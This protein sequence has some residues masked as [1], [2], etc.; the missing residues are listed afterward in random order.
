MKKAG[1]PAEFGKLRSLFWPIH[2]YE[3]KKMAPMF[4]MFFCISFVY[5][6]VRDTKD[7]LIVTAPGSGAE[8]IPFLKVWCV[9]PAAILLMLLYSKLSNTLSKERLFYTTIFPFIVFF[10]LFGFVIY[11]MRN[12]IQPHETAA[13]LRTI[14]PASAAGK[15]IIAIIENWP[16]AVFYILAELWGSM[17]LSLAFW[18]FANEITRIHEA[19]RFYGLLG[20]GANFALIFSGRAIVWAS[21]AGEGDGYAQ[22][23]KVLMFMVVIAGLAVIATYSWMQRN[24][25][26]DPLYYEAAAIPQKKKEKPKLSMKESLLFLTRSKY[27]GCIAL[28]VIAYGASI[29]LVEVVW[30]SQLK[31]QYPN[32]KEYSA[33]M[34]HFSEMTGI[35]TM[36]MFLFV[37]HNVIR[38]LGWTFAAMVTPVVLALTGSLF[39]LFMVYGESLTD[40]LVAFST[41]PLMMAVLF[42]AA[43][44]ILSKS[45][46]YSL[47]DPTKE[48]AYIPLDPESKVKGKAAIDVVGARLGKSGGSF[49]QQGLMIFMP[50]VASMAPIVGVACLLIIGVW[51]LAVRT[52]GGK[53]ETLITSLGETEVGVAKPGAAIKTTSRL[54]T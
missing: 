54:A 39:L 13:Y 26:T 9:V 44:N 10:G 49:V 41:T 8:A 14:L 31:L 48:M 2:S 21:N 23:L 12:T 32:P 24:V 22:C 19:K 11:P 18:G 38:R 15:G 4:F 28:I 40:Y 17:I 35:I 7:T 47:F 53:Y 25:L 50:T 20:I 51:I 5:T 33:F 3:L 42:G 46:K 36:F 6:I 45:A 43:Q 27:L 34:G 29:N 37:S 52:L 1:D 30:K 16:L